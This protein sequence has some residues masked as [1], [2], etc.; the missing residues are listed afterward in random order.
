MTYA[1]NPKTR[2]MIPVESISWSNSDELLGMGKTGFY[3][4]KRN[5]MACG[6]VLLGQEDFAVF[7]R[8]AKF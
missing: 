3:N 1:Y 7:E 5:L 2:Q 6:W 4:L 8:V